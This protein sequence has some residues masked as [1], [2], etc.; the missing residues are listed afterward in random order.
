MIANKTFLV[1]ANKTFLDLMESTANFLRLL[2]DDKDHIIVTH[3]DLKMENPLAS[4]A[5]VNA[6]PSAHRKS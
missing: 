1:I 3:D 6:T 4:Q 5:R 2:C